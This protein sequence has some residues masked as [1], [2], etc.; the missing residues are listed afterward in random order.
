[1]NTGTLWRN[2][3]TQTIY[4]VWLIAFDFDGQ[5]FVVYQTPDIEMSN[6]PIF[7]TQHVENSML[8]NVYKRPVYQGFRWHVEWFDPERIVNMTPVTWA[9]PASRW[10]SNFEPT[11]KSFFED[12]G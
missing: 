11:D 10:F 2:R 1:M 7:T 9:K 3:K 8:G 4:R 6:S 5:E 12:I